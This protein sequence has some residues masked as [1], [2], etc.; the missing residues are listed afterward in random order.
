M[1]ITDQYKQTHRYNPT[2]SIFQRRRLMYICFILILIIPFK[3]NSFI[4]KL[5][6]QINLFRADASD[7][8]VKD[9]YL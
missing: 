9:S 2:T 4:L 5:N 3:E 1:K 8:P 7:G 6:F